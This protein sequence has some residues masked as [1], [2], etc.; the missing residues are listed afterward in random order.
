LEQLRA[1]YKGTADC[2]PAEQKLLKDLEA[3]QKYMQRV[4]CQGRGKFKTA[5]F[6][7]QAGLL[8][9]G[10]LR[11]IRMFESAIRELHDRC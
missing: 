10:I 2:T 4:A 1:S 8:A 7:A 6:Y 3:V 9:G 5:S 11:Q